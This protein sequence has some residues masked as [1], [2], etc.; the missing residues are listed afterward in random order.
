M[1][2]SFIF[3]AQYYY[4]QG[5]AYYNEGKY[6]KAI[7]YFTQAIELNHNY[8]DAYHY[9]GNALSAL[10]KNEDAI[11]FYNKAIELNPK[12]A[13]VYYNKGNALSALGKNE[14]AIEC[15]NKAIELKP[16]FADAYNG[17]GNA[18]YALGKKVDAIEFYNKAIELNPNHANA[19]HNKGVALSALGKN[20]DAIKLYDKAISLNPNYALYYCSKGVALAALGKNEDAIEFY[21][22]AIELNPNDANAYYNKGLAL[23][24]LGKNEDAIKLYDKA[25]SLNPNYALYYCSKG[26]ALNDLAKEHE[27]LACFNKAYEISKSGNLGNNL[28]QGNINYINE[29]LSQDRE[30]LLKKLTELQKI[31]TQTEQ[32]VKTLNQNNPTVKK[33]VEQLKSLTKQKNE[34]TNKAIDSLDPT[35]ASKDTLTDKESV[36]SLSKQMSDMEAKLQAF[37]QNM[38]TDIKKDNGML[39]EGQNE[40]YTGMQ[41]GFTDVKAEQKNQISQLAKY[42]KQ[43]KATTKAIAEMQ[44]TTIAMKAKLAADSKVSQKDKQ[45]ME[46]RINTIAEKMQTLAKQDDVEAITLEMIKLISEAKITKGRLADLEDDIDN[47]LERQDKTDERLEKLELLNKTVEAMKA[48]IAADSKASNKDKQVMEGRINAIVEKMQNLANK[49]DVESIT[50]EMTKLMSEAKITKGRLADLED[51]VDSL[52][53]KQEEPI[54]INIVSSILYNNPLLNHPTLLKD[55]AKHFGISK[56]IDLSQTLS[57][58]LVEDAMSNNDSELI[59]AGIISLSLNSNH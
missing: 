29:T 17:K 55:A 52:I 13:T 7:E 21:N 46:S 9:K 41:I 27:A 56:A 50:L 51:D 58:Q 33:A 18:L 43:L 35:K 8:T 15:H 34:L 54:E 37:M 2:Q 32:A 22:K 42:G 23:S 38:F 19:Y 40:I 24:A 4:N 11:E 12:R 30:E 49:D 57:Q 3:N 1:Y 28:S 36:Q 31:T 16:N 59:L 25:I 45:V 26:K 6:H 39:K 5:E 10:G 14:D 20:E 48:K 44:Q 53:G 47:I